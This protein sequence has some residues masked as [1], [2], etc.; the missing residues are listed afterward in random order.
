[1]RGRVRTAASSIAH[2]DALAG[3]IKCF[4]VGERTP[5]ESF[6]LN[7]LHRPGDLPETAGAASE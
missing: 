1:M 6:A 4:Q 7:A 5:E 2:S 3:T